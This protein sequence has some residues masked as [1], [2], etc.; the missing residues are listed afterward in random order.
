MKSK[1][2]HI[3]DILNS[4]DGLQ[5][6]EARPFMYTRITARMQ[7]REKNIWS[8]IAVFVSKPIVA[9]ALL[10]LVFVINYFAIADRNENVQET[11]SIANSATEILQNDNAILAAN[12]YDQ[13]Q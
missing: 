10:L 13:N 11:A 6:A 8:R 4:L 3:D 7:Q 12:Y 1:E 5:R 9:L 2:Q